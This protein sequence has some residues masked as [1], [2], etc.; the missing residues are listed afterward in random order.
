MPSFPI[1]PA[2]VHAGKEKVMAKTK[3]KNI[4]ATILAIYVLN[5]LVFPV[6]IFLNKFI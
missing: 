2:M 5:N 4:A 6:F 1:P 3:I